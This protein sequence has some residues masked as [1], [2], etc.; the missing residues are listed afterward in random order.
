M[1]NSIKKESL[2]KIVENQARKHL[3]GFILENQIG[4]KGLLI[5]EMKKIYN[6]KGINWDPDDNSILTD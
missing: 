6:E 2:E 1:E 5:E 4:Y 3:Q